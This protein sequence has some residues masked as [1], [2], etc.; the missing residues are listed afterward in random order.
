[1]K[2]CVVCPSAYSASALTS[3]FGEGIMRYLC[4]D[5]INVGIYY[6]NTI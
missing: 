5:Y 4:V 2:A 1:M 3:A 6:G